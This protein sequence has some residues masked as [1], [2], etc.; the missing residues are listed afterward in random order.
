MPDNTEEILGIASSS[1]SDPAQMG[2][3][4]QT[5]SPAVNSPYYGWGGWLAF[6]CIVQI[7]IQPII[8]LV[9]SIADAS[10]FGQD[11]S[12]DVFLVIEI[13]GMLG[14]AVFGV[15]AGVNL[16]RIR[17][18]AVR[19]AKAYLVA[20]LVWS[21]L[22]AVLAYAMLEGHYQE[23]VGAQEVQGVVFTIVPFVIW[24]TYFNVSKRVKA[25]YFG[26]SETIHIVPPGV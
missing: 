15:I 11:S 10:V 14:L 2:A 7:F 25:T 6:F 12:L 26:E 19:V 1:S 13:A 16:W 21:V 24:F 8:L 5:G 20:A 3:A 9:L 18:G 17:P 23:A 22:K 4:A